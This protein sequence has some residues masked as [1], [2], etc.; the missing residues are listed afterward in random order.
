MAKCVK[1]KH[2]ISQVFWYTYMFLK[3]LSLC[4]VFCDE[5]RSQAVARKEVLVC[6]FIIWILH[7]FRQG[8]FPVILLSF[9]RSESEERVSFFTLNKNDLLVY[10]KNYHYFFFTLENFCI[11][12]Y[13]VFILC[14]GNPRKGS[15]MSIVATSSFSQSSFGVIPVVGLARLDPS[16]TIF[17]K[18]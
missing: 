14:V 9:Y 5:M 6:F 16:A 17:L 1:A 12:Q 3:Y 13:L 4:L 18:N 15:R 10:E 2:G 8:H 7:E 11:M